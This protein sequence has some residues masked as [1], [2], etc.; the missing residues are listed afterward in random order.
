LRQDNADYRLVHKGQSLGMITDAQV[1]KFEHKAK[2]V[3]TVLSFA[4]SHGIKPEAANPILL[5]K[6]SSPITQQVKLAQLISR[7]NLGY[8][9]FLD[10]VS[11]PDNKEYDREI[12]EEAEILIKYEGYIDREKENADKM[13]RLEDLKIP[14][15]F[16]YGALVS[17]SSEAKQKLKQIEPATIGQA[18]RISGVSPSDIQVLLITLGR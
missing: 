8:F 7:P 16:D 18:K 13:N 17:L 2:E 1:A 9:D 3:D 10:V 4:K 11:F 14:K 5:E 15:A 12:I 6:E